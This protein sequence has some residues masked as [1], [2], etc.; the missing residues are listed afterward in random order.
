MIECKVQNICTYTARHCLY[1]ALWRCLCV[2]VCNVCSLVINAYCP[3]DHLEIAV[4]WERFSLACRLNIG[5]SKKSIK[6]LI[7]K[8]NKYSLPSKLFQDLQFPIATVALLL[9]T[10]LCWHT[11][12]YRMLCLIWNW[13][14]VHGGKVA[15]NTETALLKWITFSPTLTLPL[16]SPKIMYKISVRAFAIDW[17]FV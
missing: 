6:G 8:V 16:L 10:V 9:F 3:R 13:K 11:H 14:E 4:R 1:L 5:F 12:S 2:P 15:S 17:L 7:I